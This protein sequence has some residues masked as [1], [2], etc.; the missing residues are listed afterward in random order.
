MYYMYFESTVRGSVV[1]FKRVVLY[2]DV[3]IHVLDLPLD[4]LLID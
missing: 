3:W 1:L 2:I 4:R